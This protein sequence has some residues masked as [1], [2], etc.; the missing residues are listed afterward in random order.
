V[1]L[2]DALT[3]LDVLPLVYAITI[4]PNNNQVIY[5]DANDASGSVE[6]PLFKPEIGYQTSGGNNYTSFNGGIEWIERTSNFFRATINPNETVTD[7]IAPYGNVTRSRVWYRT[8]GGGMQSMQKSDDG[9]LTFNV[10]TDG[11]NNTMVNKVW[12][13]P[14]PPPAYN[15]LLFS[16]E[17]GYLHL[18]PDE[19]QTW[20]NQKAVQ[21][22][23]YTWS[24]AADYMDPDSI[25]YSTGYPAWTY[26]EQRGIY[27]ISIDCFQ[28]GCDY[29]DQILNNTGVWRVITTPLIPDTIYA[30]T[31]EQ[32]I[33]LSDDNGQNWTTL[34]NG[35][36]LPMSITDIELDENGLPQL[37][38]F[39]SS[40]GD[41]TA[42]PP[43]EWWP[44][45]DENGGM[46]YFDTPTSQWL[47]V[48]GINSAAFDIERDPWDPQ[49]LFAATAQGVYQSNDN[50]QSWVLILPEVISNDLLIDPIKQGY[51]YT[52]TPHGV[53]R[54]T[55]GGVYWHDFSNG[56]LKKHV[57]SLALDPYTD[58][59]Y[60]GTS[61]N[62]VFKL[63]PEENPQPAISY[64]PVSLDIG[65]AAVGFTI[66]SSLI[67]T[68]EGESNLVIDNI[69]PADSVFT[70]PDLSLPITITPMTSV[71]LEVHF[72]PES[73]GVVNSSISFYSNDPVSP[74]SDYAVTGEGRPAELPNPDVKVNDGDG[75]VSI[76]YGQTF[77]LDLH[78]SAGDYLGQ[79]SD[80]WVKMTQPDSTILWLVNGAGWIESVTPL[81]FDVMFLQDFTDPILSL[82]MT[83]AQSGVN[84]IEFAADDN[85]DGNYDFTWSDTVNITMEQS[86][87]LLFLSPSEIYFGETVV[88][89]SKTINFAV[90]NSGEQDLVIDS[91]TP[92]VGDFE[93]VDPPIFPLTIAGGDSV[94]L[95]AR[96]TPQSEGPVQGK[97]TIQSNDPLSPDID[98]DLSGD[99]MAFVA[100]VPD[101]KANGFDDIQFVTQGSNN[102]IT[103]S[104][105]PG[106]YTG[107]EADW[108]VVIFTL[109][110]ET[111]VW[112]PVSY[113]SY[114]SPLFK[115]TTFEIFNMSSFTPGAYAIMFG[116]DMFPNGTVDFNQLMYDLVPVVIT[117]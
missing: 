67:V 38:S 111:Q 13:H 33:M 8:T 59:L 110:T 84:D 64:N 95:A 44:D 3:G 27:R 75:P 39:R 14:S 66:N 5:V 83:L 35:L 117:P 21:D 78:L 96:F 102:P 57:M 17:E 97:F 69:V 2:P 54:S 73:V 10:I 106:S 105:D 55:N 4:D 82:D 85:A 76:S 107:T 77:S 114:E 116:V 24:F 68:N 1:P 18:L 99:G 34:N 74:V 71:A 43:Q 94:V 53:L 112:T 62:S 101:V 48:S 113:G 20:Q 16:S 86:A 92:D 50:G 15:S 52:A 90:A 47:L 87:P 79:E 104:L 89:F 12:V 11:L 70:L 109:N 7:F 72:S 63:L 23:L 49:M 26:A 108:W 45:P 46:Y 100:L 81:R 51:V 115:L 9:G 19:S 61:G 31:Q 91:I 80:I 6:Q 93:L 56:L 36:T 58:I 103:L 42:D 25:Y 37:A 41:C 60:T 22:Y 88:G 98:F 29:G 65:I 32:G 30:A 40:N 28:L